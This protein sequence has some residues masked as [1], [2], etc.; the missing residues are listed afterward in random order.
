MHAYTGNGNSN[1]TNAGSVTLNKTNVTLK[2]GKTFKITAKVN[3][4][5]NKKKLMS[6]SHAQEIRDATSNSKIAVVD[7]SGKITAKGKGT[8][9][10]YAYAHNG[11]SKQVKVTVK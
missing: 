7:G 2:K 1:Y 5:N 3:K 4:V 10:I 9:Y 6:K 8:C 11:V